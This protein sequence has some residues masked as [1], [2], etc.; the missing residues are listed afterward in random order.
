[1][2]R[3]TKINSKNQD[4]VYGKKFICS[5]VETDELWLIHGDGTVEV[6]GRETRGKWVKSVF[7]RP[8]DLASVKAKF[9][10]ADDG[11][12]QLVEIIE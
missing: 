1:M 7:S 9:W 12:V 4:E 6:I 2:K 5:S 10:P 11:T 8:G 3:G